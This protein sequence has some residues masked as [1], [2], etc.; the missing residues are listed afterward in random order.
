MTLNRWRREPPIAQAL[1]QFR[2]RID[3]MMD[4]GLRPEHFIFAA[5][6]GRNLEY[7]TGFVFQIEADTPQGAAAGCGRRSL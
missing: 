7:Y 5:T 1:G 6:F 4:L 3:A 2:R